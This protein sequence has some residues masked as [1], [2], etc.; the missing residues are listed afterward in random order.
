MAWLAIHRHAATMRLH[1]V[2]HQRQAE[3]RAGHAAAGLG[4]TVEAIENFVMLRGGD[5]DTM[6]LDA[7]NGPRTLAIHGNVAAVTLNLTVTASNVEESLNTPTR[8][9]RST[10]SPAAPRP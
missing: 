2:G 1:D 9:T 10:W 7:D 5:A 4:R 3:T 8:T 6:V